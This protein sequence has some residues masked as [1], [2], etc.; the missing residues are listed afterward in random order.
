MICRSGLANGDIENVSGAPANHK[1][2]ITGQKP[3]GRRIRKSSATVLLAAATVLFFVLGCENEPF[4]LLPLGITLVEYVGTPNSSQYTYKDK[5]I[6]TFAKLSSGDTVQFMKFYYDRDKL[7]RI[8]IDSTADSH[9]LLRINHVS[10]ETTIDSLFTVTPSSQTHD[11]TRLYSYNDQ[12][13]LY[14]ID[15]FPDTGGVATTIYKLEWTGENVSLLTRETLEQG[16]VVSSTTVAV[17]H[18]DRL[19]I[20]SNDAEY[21]YTL[22]LDELYWLSANNPIRFKRDT[23]KEVTYTYFYNVMG[24]PSHIRTDKGQQIGHTYVEMR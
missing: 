12:Q 23:L 1:P 6:R 9:N 18:D 11:R 14:R 16:A 21:I 10:P 19:G 3:P 13:R 7:A 15:V 8:V 4:D 5:R 17:G 24:Y 20:Y 22:S 2:E